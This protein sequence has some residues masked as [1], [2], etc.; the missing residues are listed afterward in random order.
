M[1]CRQGSCKGLQQ[2][3]GAWAP[4]GQS[5]RAH[6][7]AARALWGGGDDALLIVLL[8]LNIV[9]IALYAALHAASIRSGG[10]QDSTSMR[11]QAVDEKLIKNSLCL[12]PG[13]KPCHDKYVCAGGCSGLCCLLC[14]T[15]MSST[16]QSGQTLFFE[17]QRDIHSTQKTCMQLFK[18]ALSVSL[19]IS[20]RPT[21]T[22]TT[23][24]EG[25]PANLLWWIRLQNLQ[26]GQVGKISLISS[27][28]AA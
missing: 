7:R 10:P 18:T 6:R 9:H 28:A 13:T 24:K 25:S 8:A 12:G 19:A 1:T 27:L 26:I 2:A 5:G 3:H 11:H 15:E 22:N 21:V 14:Q 17:A 20:V 23:Q 4:S 16:L